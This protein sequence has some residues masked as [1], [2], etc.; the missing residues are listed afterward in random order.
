[1]GDSGS[2]GASQGLLHEPHSSAAGAIAEMGG[3][4]FLTIV[5]TGSTRSLIFRS[6]LGPIRNPWNAS[7]RR[8]SRPLEILQIEY[9]RLIYGWLICPP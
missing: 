3:L 5:I 7:R 4:G 8:G 2:R 6:R 9:E 1:M